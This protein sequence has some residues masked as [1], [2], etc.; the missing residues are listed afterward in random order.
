[1]LAGPGRAGR[2]GLR[3]SFSGPPR[4]LEPV[5]SADWLW[6]LREPELLDV[7]ERPLFAGGTAQRVDET[8]L[9]GGLRLEVEVAFLRPSNQRSE[10]LR[11]RHDIS[12]G[13]LRL[14]T[15]WALEAGHAR[16]IDARRL[17]HNRRNCVR[18]AHATVVW[19]RPR[20]RQHGDASQPAKRS[21]CF[22]SVH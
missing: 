17:T 11:A 3:G 20:R 14:V 4:Q 5:G 21:V 13:G 16:S 1:M 8:F 18:D 19:R 7:M 12:Y 10:K 22:R 2:L 9:A 6:I 15:L